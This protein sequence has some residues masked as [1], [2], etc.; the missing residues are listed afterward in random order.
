[1]VAAEYT[2]ALACVEAE[3]CE[4]C[5]RWLTVVDETRRTELTLKRDAVKCERVGARA[6]FGGGLTAEDQAACI[7]ER[8]VLELRGE[9]GRRAWATG[10]A[11]KGSA[12]AAVAEVMNT[13]GTE[14]DRHE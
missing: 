9:R 2:A 14:G 11:A 6:G 7:A 5:A 10:R 13:H 3:G 4:R 8:Q 12:N 1:M